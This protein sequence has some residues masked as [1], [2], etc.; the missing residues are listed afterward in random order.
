[1]S[2]LGAGFAAGIIIGLIIGLSGGRT[3]KPWSAMN[4][5]EKGLR[6]VIM[7]VLAILLVGSFIM[8]LA[9]QG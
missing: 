6:A 8:L 5:K 4:K 7:L 1:M 3:Q 9:V 2:E